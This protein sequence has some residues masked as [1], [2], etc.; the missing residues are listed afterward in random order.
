MLTAHDKRIARLAVNRYGVDPVRVRHACV[1][2]LERRRSLGK[3]SHLD[4]VEILV[5]KKLLSSSQ[6]CALR[7]ELE[8]TIVAPPSNNAPPQPNGSHS[9]LERVGS[10]L[11]LRKI[12]EGAMGEVF[13]AYDE[14]RQRH[15]AV[16]ILA[17]HLQENSALVE[18]FMREAELASRLNHP[19]IVR[20]Y[21]AAFDP[22]RNVRYLVM[23]YVD[24]FSAQDYLDRHGRFSIEDA[25]HV[26]LDV[27]H[28]L[29]YA[30]AHNIIHRDIKPENILITR[31]GVAKLADL[32]LSKQ[33]DQSSTLT[34]MRQGFGTPYYMAYEQAM[35][36][37]D[38]D[39]RSDI[40]SLGATL[41]H[42][43][44]GR[45][46]FD[47][48]NQVE[49]LE[50]KDRGIFTPAHIANPEIPEE[51][52]AI[53]DRM[54]A[55][56]PKARFQTVSEIIVAL[57]RTGL[58]GRYLS[59][60]DQDLAQRDPVAQ[61]R[62]QALESA[63]VFDLPQTPARGAIWYVREKTS[64]GKVRLRRLTTEKVVE[65]IE[66]GQLT[67]GTE[68]GPTTEGPFHKLGHYA[69]FREA[70]EKASL[71]KSVGSVSSPLGYGRRWMWW[72]IGVAL[73]VAAIGILIILIS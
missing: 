18:R 57:E 24:G 44:T 54:L 7:E 67:A 59:F 52:S 13:Y 50:K 16:K 19:N 20:G 14:E 63:T 25:L 26:I 42:M 3:S 72:L 45:V 43:L 33:T 10:Y 9:G 15:V 49:I 69:R 36:A 62:A 68:I 23:E 39:E 22:E 66:Q 37:R 70:L 35:N 61:M 21:G 30:H 60:A 17:K 31:S 58:V 27:A 55:R 6:A 65:A 41:Y 8:K 1:E 32:G 34:G 38:A 64:A 40:F 5:E 11:L 71:S 53:L 28:A 12:G 47:G 73:V 48:K 46:P 56:E 2:L 4:L 51:L 29:E